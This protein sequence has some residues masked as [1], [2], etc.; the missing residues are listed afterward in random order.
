MSAADPIPAIR[1]EDAT[2]ETAALFADLRATLGVPF[3]NLIWRHLATIPGGLDWTW[4]LAKPLY[5][6]ADLDQA[7][8]ALRD[9]AALPELAPIPEAV[10]DCAGIGAADRA[11]IAGL[12]RDYNHANGVNFL[13]LLTAVSVLR[14]DAA[15]RPVALRAPSGRGIAGAP[16][17][18]VRPLPPLSDLAPPVVATVRELDRFGR[19]G[20]NDAVASLYRHLGYWPVFLAMSHAGLAPYHR[21]GALA[22]AQARV[23][24]A[25][26]E[27]AGRLAELVGREPG[28]LDPDTRRRVFAALDEFT[29]LM[30]GR[31][32]VMG[33]ALLTQLPRA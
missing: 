18:T 20:D 17:G 3:V 28:T 12:I 19:L 30:I 29:R 16:S 21:N 7:A 32:V 2:G 9:V 22:G 5:E 23:I 8:A 31:M 27:H 15:S 26:R 10:W 33:S 14:P 25:G 1:E 4:A 6:T 24:A 13:A 11:E